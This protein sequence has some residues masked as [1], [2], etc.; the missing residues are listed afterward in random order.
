M[1]L[2]DLS[3]LPGD[4]SGGLDRVIPTK[5]SRFL[6][7]S[8]GREFG[9]SSIGVQVCFALDAKL[10]FLFNSASLRS[11]FSLVIIWFS[12][13][14]VIVHCGYVVPSMVLSQRRVQMR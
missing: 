6:C 1:G 2:R 3:G 13:L 10:G 4:S 7:Q 14:V 11:M 9:W 5:T 8:A 12:H